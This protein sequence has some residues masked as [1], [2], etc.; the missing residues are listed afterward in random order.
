MVSL[1]DLGTGKAE[2]FFLSPWYVMVKYTKAIGQSPMK[3][4]NHFMCDIKPKKI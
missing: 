1:R 3:Q 4:K 2:A